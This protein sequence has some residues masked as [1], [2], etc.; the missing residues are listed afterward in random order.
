MIDR[1]RDLSTWISRTLSGA[2]GFFLG[3]VLI[4]GIATGGLVAAGSAA[5]S[6]LFQP[7][8][9]DSPHEL[10]LLQVHSPEMGWNL[11]LSPAMVAELREDDWHRGIAAFNQG[12]DLAGSE[13]QSWRTAQIEPGLLELL[14]VQPIAGRAFV[15]EDA[16]SDATGTVLLSE[17]VWR[18]RFGASADAIGQRIELDGNQ[19]EVIGVMPAS[20]S[21]PESGIDVWMPL[22]F[23]PET[24]EPQALNEI[25]LVDA[26]LTRL[27][28]GQSPV[29]AAGSMEARFGDDPR[30]RNI[31][32]NIGLEFKLVPVRES[33]MGVQRLALSLL[34]AATA[35]ILLISVMNLSGLWMARWLQRTREVAVRAAIGA[36]RWQPLRS[37]AAEFAAVAA[38]GLALGLVLAEA[39]I[40]T[41]YGLD[42]LDSSNP[43]TVNLG[44]VG[45]LLGLGIA[46]AAAAPILMAVAWQTQ[47]LATNPARVLGTEGRGMQGVGRRSRRVLIATQV[48]M[49]TALL[50]VLG[51]LL[52]SWVNLVNEDLGFEPDHL[53][54][55]HIVPGPANADSGEPDE[56]L[57]AAMDRLSGLP[58]IAEVSFAL[59]SPFGWAEIISTYEPP[60]RPGAT[61]PMRISHIGP[62]YFSTTGI[63]VLAGRIPEPVG[64]DSTTNQVV[65]DQ[66]FA[67]RHFPSLDPLG[68][69]FRYGSGPD[70]ETSEVEIAAVVATTRHRSPSEEITM[71]TVSFLLE[72]PQAHHQLLAR[73]VIPPEQVIGP[74]RSV[75]VEELGSKRVAN[76]VSGTDRVRQTIAERRPQM[77]LLA[78]FGALATGLAAVGLYALMTYTAQARIP[79]L[80]LRIALGAGPIRTGLT[81][82][83]DGLKLIVAGMIPGAFLAWLG[84]RLIAEQLYRVAPWHPALWIG[85]ITLLTLVLLIAGLRPA[86]A[87]MRVQPMDALR[88]Q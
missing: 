69:R 78:L 74:V 13:G 67:E 52:L 82:L 2:P 14:G 32:E 71:P 56:A 44:L 15:S 75:L 18:G 77:I 20:L 38:G 48:A 51:L 17:G 65:V 9:F 43:L 50:G 22:T 19:L 35:V 16:L 46:A 28:P 86:L 88:E 68:Q 66:L 63:P 5:W 87:A 23:P 76:V 4:L 7:L 58:G 41:L 3:A 12:R 47:Y 49:A 57:E 85:V 6:I 54:M 61:A 34:V 70:G 36:G 55:V 72:R 11:S 37:T 33:W 62:G 26:V 45:P 24:L 60:G 42:V 79:E 30:L 31:R 29:A 64:S 25:G 80:G 1:L 21:V 10:Q 53:V 40:R 59:V 84:T 39:G 8:P 73:T 27:A 83:G 81:I